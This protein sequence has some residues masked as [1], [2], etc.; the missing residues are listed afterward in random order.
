M[1][2]RENSKIISL[3]IGI[4]ISILFACYVPYI[5]TAFNCKV[6]TFEAYRKSW[7]NDFEN[8]M[9]KWDG[10]Y[11]QP[12]GYMNFE[13]MTIIFYIFLSLKIAIVG[14]IFYKLTYKVINRKRLK[15]KEY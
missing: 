13:K 5:E 6:C 11:P 15:E 9:P 1:K 12:M 7:Y 2:I 10:T 14:I 8:V 3:I 4:A